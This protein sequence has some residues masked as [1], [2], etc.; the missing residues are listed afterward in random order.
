MKPFKPFVVAVLLLLTDV[1]AVGLNPGLTL[2]GPSSSL[3]L[4]DFKRLV[5]SDEENLA[6]RFW[7]EFALPHFQSRFRQSTRERF[8]GMNTDEDA[9]PI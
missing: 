9:V 1:T 5:G 7:R 4:E 2:I 8:L 3:T 6:Q